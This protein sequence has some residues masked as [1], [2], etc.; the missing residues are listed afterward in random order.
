VTRHG[1][2]LLAAALVS[3][4]STLAAP[5]PAPAAYT[6]DDLVRDARAFHGS[7]LAHLGDLV[8]EQEATFTASAGGSTMSSVLRQ[9]GKKWRVDGQM[10]AG[11]MGGAKGAA[12]GN[13]IETTMLYDGESLWSFA[14]GIKAKVPGSMAGPSGAAPVHW[15]EPAAGSTVVGEETVSGRACWV[16]EGP[17]AP[18]APAGGGVKTWIDKKAFVHV[19]TEAHL[20]GKT[21]RTVFS[22][23]RTM[24]GEFVVPYQAEVF[25]DGVKTMTSR[26]TKLEH[27]V[28]LSDD[29]FDPEKLGGS[30]GAG[31]TV[32]VQKLLRQAEEMQKKAAAKG[33]KPH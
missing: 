11:A 15:Q 1:A 25:S 31:T 30:Q 29:L 26:V 28:G 14:L 7:A 20:S 33:G 10:D 22:D 23:F 8:I 2:A 27:G 32:D 6:I 9:K 18:N 13:T 12:A 3:T 5:R 19:Q 21:V 16:V 24:E 17:A 4:L